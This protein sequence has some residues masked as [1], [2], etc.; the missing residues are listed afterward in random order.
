MD[1]LPAELD[2]DLQEHDADEDESGDQ[3]LSGV[4]VEGAASVDQVE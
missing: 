4:V 3:G 1:L 2:P